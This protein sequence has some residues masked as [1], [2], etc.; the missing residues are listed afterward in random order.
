VL[1]LRD[2]PVNVVLVCHEKID[3][4]DGDRI[5]RPLTG[6]QQL[7][8]LLIG[9][10]DVVAYCGEVPATEDRPK[11]WVG[12]FVQERGRRAKDRSGA[13]G[14][15]RDIDLAE[16][17]VVYREAMTPDTSDLPFDAEEPSEPTLDDVMTGRA[18]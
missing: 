9:E 6:G 7:P 4:G 15:F 5:I 2:K 1:F 17:L 11:R 12:Q 18:A 14:N 16:W 10:V 13:L 3:E 8:E